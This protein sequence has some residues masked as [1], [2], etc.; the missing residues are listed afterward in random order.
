MKL[1]ISFDLPDL[2][3]SLAIAKQVVDYCHILEIGTILL[4]KYGISVISAFKEQFPHKTILTDT[5]IVDRG[6]DVTTLFGS[7]PTDWLTVTAGTSKD[8]IHSVCTTAHNANKKVMFDLIDSRSL[9]QAALD[10]QSFGIDALLFHQTY[11]EQESLVFL[12]QWDMV[13][14]NTS[15]PIFISAHINREIIEKIISISP[16]GIV[17][18][19]AI[20][21]STNPS[22]EAQFFYELVSQK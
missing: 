3:K 5:K 22:Q 20:T 14:G 19:K 9:G 6:R 7:T 8:V 15:L 21:E 4:Y 1:Q 11:D 16:D 18:G 13:R 12:D 17:V 10:A 2:D